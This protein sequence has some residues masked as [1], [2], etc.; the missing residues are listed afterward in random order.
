MRLEAQKEAIWQCNHCS[1]CSEI[2]CDQAGFYKACPVY[3]LL[4][5]ENYT[6]RGHNTIA[7]YLLEGSLTYNQELAD[8]IYKCTT[9]MLCEE[10]CKPMGNAVAGLGGYGLKSILDSMI[11]PLQIEMKPIPSVAIMEAMR[12]DCV[13]RG[14]E[15]QGLKEAAGR[16][17]KTGNCYGKPAADR[18]R[19]SAGL[20]LADQSETILFVGDA[21]AYE[22]PEVA[23]ATARIL[24]HAGKPFGILAD[25]R[26]SGAVLFRTGNLSLGEKMAR[27]NLALLEHAKEV[28]CLSASDCYCIAKDWTM[29]AGKLPFR[30]R[31]ISTVLADLIK[32]RRIRFMKNIPIIATYEDPCYLGRGMN[33]YADP[34]IVL[35]AIPGLRFVE[36]Y[37]TA[38]AAWCCGN[39][40]GVPEADPELSLHLG[41]RKLPLVAS[42]QAS[43]IATACPEVKVHLDKVMTHAEQAYQVKDIVELVAQSIGV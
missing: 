10:V 24:Q 28:I 6:A 35:N 18:T 31:H 25:E 36:I 37:P 1:M 19:W 3:Q 4:E 40:G 5:F 16:I 41:Q 7:L 33:Q 23:Q 2:V 26:S 32:K 27:H 20:N 17:E 13:E 14:L 30:I 11:K 34:R 22:A 42:T 29:V 12:A 21:A 38:H 43:M 8:V 39:C 9:C 15:P